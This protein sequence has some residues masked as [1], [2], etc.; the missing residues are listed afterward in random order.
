MEKWMVAE[1]LKRRNGRGW[2]MV[3]VVKWVRGGN[4]RSGGVLGWRNG[5]SSNSG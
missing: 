3:G 1:W 5:W 2:E 4:G